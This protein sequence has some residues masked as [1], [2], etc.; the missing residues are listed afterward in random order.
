MVFVVIEVSDPF[1]VSDSRPPLLPGVFA[2]VLIEGKTLRNAVAVPRDAIREGNG[3]WL[4]N[5]NR[6]HIQA[7]DIVRADKDFAYVVSGL[8]DRAYVVTSSLDAVVDGMQVRTEA[9]G[10]A[11]P[12]Q[13]K[14]D[15]RQPEKQ[16]EN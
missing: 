14:Q 4:V 11:Q 2:E 13:P 10:A 9:D 5:D 15:S 16:E 6:L 12:E 7:L 1:K 8:R 3:V